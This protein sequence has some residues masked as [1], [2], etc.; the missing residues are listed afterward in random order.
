MQT[1]RRILTVLCIVLTV[2]ANAWLW[3]AAGAAPRVPLSPGDVNRDGLVN[4]FD[5]VAVSVRYGI[6][7]PLGTPEDTNADG[8]VDI[9]DLV[10]V[11]ASFG[12][13]PSVPTTTAIPT[14]PTATWTPIKNNT[15]T[16]LPARPTATSRPPPVRNCCKYCCK[17][18][19]C[20]NSC[21]SRR[22]TCHKP[23]G[24]ACWAPGCGP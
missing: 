9:F 20:G 19:P 13:A 2:L 17:G 5:L 14:Q 18:K 6:R 15:P 23:P 22:Y 10:V 16:A 11:A 4:L 3:P 24:C 21:I 12:S 8:K 1:K 7:V